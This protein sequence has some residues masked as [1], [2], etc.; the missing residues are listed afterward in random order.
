M[1]FERSGVSSIHVLKQGCLRMVAVPP[2]WWV[3]TI[4]RVS[5]E[6]CWP[7][8]PVNSVW[9]MPSVNYEHDD[10][11]HMSPKTISCKPLKCH[12]A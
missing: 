11:H 9:H 12:D 5:S 8:K 10:D 3:F 7:K 2:R 6:K 1:T 4:E